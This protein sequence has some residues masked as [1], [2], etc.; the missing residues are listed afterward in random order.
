MIITPSQEDIETAVRAFLLDVTSLADVILGEVNR[1]PSPEDANYIVFW[2]LLRAR[3]STNVQGLVDC[4]FTASI[5]GT[6]MTVTDVEYGELEVGYPVYG[7]GVTLGTSI[8]SGPGGVGS[9]VVSPSQNVAARSMSSGSL[10]VTQSTGVTMQVDI[11]GPNS[12]DHAEVITTL[13][14][15]GYAVDFLQAINS[16]I[17]P[18]GASDP[19]QM[20]FS[21]GEQQTDIRWIVDLELQVNQTVVVPQPFAETVDVGVISVEATYPS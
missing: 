11:H 2:P 21:T 16:E 12:G 9:Y 4:V 15:D 13:F 20:P 3:L 6:A 19:R 10:D 8:I 18:L 17:T 7:V 14:R 5:A 1:V